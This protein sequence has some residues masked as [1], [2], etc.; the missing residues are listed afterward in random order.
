MEQKKEITCYIVQ[1]VH[2]CCLPTRKR[3]K[4]IS[5]QE[6]N[7]YIKKKVSKKEDSIKQKQESEEKKIEEERSKIEREKEKREDR[8]ERKN[9]YLKLSR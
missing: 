4:R 1:E 7:N 9:I 3:G 5:W 2:V 8:R 6:K